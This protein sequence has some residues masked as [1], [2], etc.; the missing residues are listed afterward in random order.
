MLLIL[1]VK[2]VSIPYSTIKIDNRARELSVRMRVSIPYST[3]KIQ[4]RK[5]SQKALFSFNSL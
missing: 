1:L 3:I 4:L 2:V 5:Y